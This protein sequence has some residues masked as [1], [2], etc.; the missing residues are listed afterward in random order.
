MS[1]S[2]WLWRCPVRNGNAR[3]V[4]PEERKEDRGHGNTFF[5]TSVREQSHDLS[6]Q[7]TTNFSA[8]PR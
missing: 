4:F 6:M 1:L 7:C 3:T 5:Q 8:L 2:S